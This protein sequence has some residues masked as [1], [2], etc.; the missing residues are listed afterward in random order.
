MAQRRD[1]S[2]ARRA[3]GFTLLEVMVVVVIIGLLATVTVTVVM[4]RVEKA[5]RDLCKATLK[6][7]EKGVELFKLDHGR[8]PRSIGELASPPKGGTTRYLTDAEPLDPWKHPIQYVPAG[9]DEKPFEL[10][11]LGADGQEGG[12]GDDA[13][14]SNRD[15][16]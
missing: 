1:V 11:S 2:A 10:R 12:S 9:G 15:P 14:L 6:D 7:M 4:G 16:R 8:Y 3:A 13:D 5:K